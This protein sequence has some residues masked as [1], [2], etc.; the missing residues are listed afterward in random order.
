MV[1]TFSS[2]SVPIAYQ[3]LSEGGYFRPV[4]QNRLIPGRKA[5]PLWQKPT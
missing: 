2:I 4:Q 1:R 5:H 3:E